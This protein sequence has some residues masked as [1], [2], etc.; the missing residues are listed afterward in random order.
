MNRNQGKSWHTQPRTAYRVVTVCM[1][2]KAMQGN[3]RR[4]SQYSSVWIDPALS[5]YFSR[6]TDEQNQSEVSFLE[7]PL[8][9]PAQSAPLLP[10]RASLNLPEPNSARRRNPTTPIPPRASAQPVSSITVRPRYS[11]ASIY[12]APESDIARMPTLPPTM[13]EYESSD[14]QAGSSLSS[15]SLVVDAPTI[16]DAPGT[17]GRELTSDAIQTRPP[18]PMQRAALAIEEIDT[19]PPLKTRQ[20]VLTIDEIDTIPARTAQQQGAGIGALD[21]L[22]PQTR[23]LLPNNALMVVPTILPMSPTSAPAA[24]MALTD[25]S[26]SWTAGGAAQSKYAQRIAERKGGKGIVWYGSQDV[27]AITR[28]RSPFR[29]PVDRVRWWL[30]RPGHIEFV[31]WIGGTILLMI[32]TVALLL[33]TAV[34]LFWGVPGQATK[35]TT[36][37]TNTTSISGSPAGHTTTMTL[38]LNESSPL[39]AGQALRL[40]GQ[41]FSSRAAITLTHDQGQPCQ[42][43]STRADA[44]GAFSVTLDDSTWTAG[45][46]RVT[47]QDTSSGRAASLTITLAPGPI[48]KKPAATP[49]AN[50]PTPVGGVQSTPVNSNPSPTPK[51]TATST[52]SPTPTQTTPTPGITPTISPTA[53]TTPSTQNTVTPTS[54]T[55]GAGN[56]ASLSLDMAAQSSPIASSWLWLLLALGCSAALLMLGLVGVMRRR[57]RA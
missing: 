49:A 54:G 37:G 11:R 56:A 51:P 14:F 28:G 38:I 1:K 5:P 17:P 9:H 44:Q 23:S 4:A 46:H 35:A 53:G 30:L 24:S 31:L 41:D 7:H 18:A 27:S 13:W 33:A 45:T 21:V 16:P 20:H 8:Q 26:A 40:R 12:P 48:G 39:V 2:D 6:K 3:K 29:H 15:L 32:V 22:P 36:Q 55:P 43:G 47:A 25:A 10:A 52:P 57:D 19:I 50:A 42:P 34:N